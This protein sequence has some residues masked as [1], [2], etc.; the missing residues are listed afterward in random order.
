MKVYHG[1]YLYIR[2][3]DLS[4]S[5]HNR[6]FGRGFYVTKLH[7]QAQAWA[8]R[9][10]EDHHTEGVVTEF[11]FDEY[12]WE[13]DEMRTLR[14]ETYSKEWLEFIVRNRQNRSRRTIHNYDIVEGPVADDAVSVRV[15]DYLRGDLSQ[16]D[17]LEELKFKIPTHQICFCSVAS[18][19]ALEYPDN[20][21]VW[22]IEH[23]GKEIVMSLVTEYHLE[24]HHAADLFYNSATF[25]QLSD[26]TTN[27]YEKP[28]QDIYKMLK[29]EACFSSL[30]YFQ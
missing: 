14:F 25:A 1:S 30:N 8:N 19:Q 4:M 3:I 16:Q 5:R 11:E 15:N 17:F 18:L 23:I 10:G 26:L 12:I 27:L 13:D 28:W 29:E 22:N 6:D 21:P 9:K 24:A 7:E 20:R 2:S